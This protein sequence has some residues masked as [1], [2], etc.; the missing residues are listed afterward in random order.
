MTP[1]QAGF[2]S[3]QTQ[4]LLQR[5]LDAAGEF[6]DAASQRLNKFSDPRARLVRKRRFA[7]WTGLF[8]LLS[9]LFWIAVTG[10]LATWSIPWWVLLITGLIAA[11]AAAPATLLLWRWR[12]LMGEPMPSPRPGLSR[13]VPPLGSAARGAV[14]ALST[15]E[16]A[17]FNL[18]GVMERGQLLPID[19]IR[20]LTDVARTV[21]STITANATDIVAMEKAVAASPSSRASLTPT[22]NSFAA[23]LNHGVVQYNE[24]VD[25]A[26]QLV[27]TSQSPMSRQHYRD[28]LVSA[29]DRMLGW[30][31]AY[32]ELGR[33]SA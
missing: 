19:E 10:V 29:T 9:C 14:V 31:Q 11:G 24:M 15:G 30:A 8:F 4:S 2:A 23:Q 13:R 32:D 22:I 5:G 28:E 3:R 17:M 27:S 21:A 6:A 33:R 18:I 26:A 12:W 20:E 1:K 7:L 16:R 25:A